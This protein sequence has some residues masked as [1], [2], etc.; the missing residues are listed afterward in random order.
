MA[1][2]LKDK[3]DQMKKYRDQGAYNI[4]VLESSDIALVNHIT[5]YKAFL[6]ASETAPIPNIDE[7]W[8]ASTY[9]PEDACDLLCFLGPEEIMDAVNPPNFQLG[10][11]HSPMWRE[12]IEQDEEARGSLDLGSYIRLQSR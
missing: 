7:V 9:G 11:R 2:A 10:P 8:L 6:Q 4:L 12:A 5:L 1:R 3:N